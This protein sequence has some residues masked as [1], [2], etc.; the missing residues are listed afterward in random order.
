[1]LRIINGQI[2]YAQTEMLLGEKALAEIISWKKGSFHE[3]PL[4]EEQDANI[5]GS[6]EF[7]LME[8]TQRAD[9]CLAIEEK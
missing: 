9:E 7:V 5:L 4:E 6:W 1:M 3:E 2:R 8:A